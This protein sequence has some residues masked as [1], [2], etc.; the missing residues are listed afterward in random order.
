MG[1]FVWFGVG[2]LASPFLTTGRHRLERV[3]MDETEGGLRVS[4]R[5]QWGSGTKHCTWVGGGCRVVGPDGKP[6]ARDDGLAFH[7]G[8]TG[9]QKDAACFVVSSGGAVS[10]SIRLE[11][12]GDGL[13]PQAGHAR[14]TSR[15]PHGGF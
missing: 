10:K 5:W 7:I 4:G 12:A 6:A 8:L 9:Q 1:N 13:R 3:E 15:P 14:R 11:C 2:P